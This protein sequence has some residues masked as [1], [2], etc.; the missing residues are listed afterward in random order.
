MS[1]HTGFTAPSRA[2]G[3]GLPGKRPHGNRIRAWGLSA[4]RSAPILHRISSLDG[5]RATGEYTSPCTVV[6]SASSKN[7]PGKLYGG[8]TFLYGAPRRKSVE[9]KRRSR[10]CFL[11]FFKLTSRCCFLATTRLGRSDNNAQL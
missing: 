8:G 5:V 7:K 11:L 3:N 10:H 2:T 6:G 9:I 1:I 4:S